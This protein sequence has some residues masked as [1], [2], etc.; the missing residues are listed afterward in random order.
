MRDYLLGILNQQKS[1]IEQLFLNIPIQ[2]GRNTSSIEIPARQSLSNLLIR[3]DALKSDVLI[4]P[5]IYPVFIRAYNI[6]K[7]EIDR[8]EAIQ[9]TTLNRWN[10]NDKRVN[11][12][13]NKIT[14]EISFPISPP[15]VACSS[16]RYFYTIPSSFIIFIPLTEGN[17]LLHIPD[18]FHELGH[19][20]LAF[21]DDKRLV[22]FQKSFL[23]AV[24][25]AKKFVA[26]ELQKE[27]RNR[28]P[29]S[30]KKYLSSWYRSWHHWV[31]EL[32]CDLFSVATLGPAFAWS[33]LHLCISIGADPYST[34]LFSASTHPPDATRMEVML[35]ILELLGYSNENNMIEMKWHGFLSLRNATPSPEYRRCFPDSLLNEIAACAHKGVKG[36]KCNIAEPSMKGPCR[37]LLNEAW[38]K[39]WETPESYAD[40]EK[41]A[42]KRL[43]SPAT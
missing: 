43:M 28:G 31:E 40:W 13:V 21:A 42:V 41:D 32:F 19:S 4:S 2:H 22:P 3:I 5:K 8:I 16:Q 11:D 1:K 24:T 33:H 20:L 10:D 14:T 35:K 18:L 25:K 37:C 7:E 27:E 9:I 23:V 39:F 26:D 36:L 29:T 6:I 15:A 34:P 12:L 17:F 38:V 30:F